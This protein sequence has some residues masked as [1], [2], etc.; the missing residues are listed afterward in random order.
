MR[1]RKGKGAGMCMQRLCERDPFFPFL[2]FT[3][4]GNKIPV[5]SRTKQ[6]GAGGRAAKRVSSPPN[7]F[8]ARKVCSR[9]YEERHVLS[10]RI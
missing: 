1:E 7:S 2:F 4:K 5:Q 9:L 10:V 3:I 6:K 8:D